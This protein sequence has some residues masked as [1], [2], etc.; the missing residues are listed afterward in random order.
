MTRSRAYARGAAD[1]G[2]MNDIR[3]LVPSDIPAARAEQQQRAARNFIHAVRMVASHGGLGGA[4]AGAEAGRVAPSVV[5]VIRAAQPAATLTEPFRA[6][7]SAWLQSLSQNSAFDAMVGNMLPASMDMRFGV[8]TQSFVADEVLEGAGKKVQSLTLASAD[9]LLPRKAATIIV[10]TAEMARFSG[11]T[12]LIDTELRTGVAVGTDTIFFTEI[13]NGTTPIPSAGA[14][15]A[16]TITDITALLAAVS[17]NAQSKPYFIFSPAAVK[18]LL[19]KT[20]SGTRVWIDATWAGGGLLG[21][22]LLISDGLPSGT[23]VLLDATA[24]AAVPG[25]VNI[26]SSRAASLQ[27]DDAPTQASTGG[28]PAAPTPTSL[29]SLFQTNSVAA[30]AERSF[31]FKLLRAD[32]AASL[33]GV[34]Y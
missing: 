29:V 14:T 20:V 5:D 26:D 31:A 24:V 22:P 19:G 17:L 4:L 33:S 13:V 3:P 21:V 12:S 25:E 2:G 32:A 7:S 34:S 11:A 30:R 9:P 15:A 18:A 1:I 23:A 28:S 27:L 16:N 6:A 8:S 10:T